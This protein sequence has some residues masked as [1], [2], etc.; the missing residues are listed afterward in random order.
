M[1]KNI[2]LRGPDDY[3]RDL[4]I[5]S[6]AIKASATYLHLQTGKDME[7][8]IAFVTNI[9]STGGELSLIPKQVKVVR[10]NAV[11]DR[12][13]ALIGI[14]TLLTKVITDK[15]ILSGNMV[16]YTSS[17]IERSMTSEYIEG[18][19]ANRSVIKKTGLDAFQISNTTLYALCNNREYVLKVLNNSV[20]G[21]HASPHNP[22]YLK[23][24][25][26]ALCSN[27]RI[28]VSYS[29][30]STERLI[31]GNR[32]YYNKDMVIANILAIINNTDFIQ[33]EHIIAE[34]KLHI[35]TV[36]ETLSV[37]LRSIKFYWRN[38]N[39]VMGI[40]E[41]IEKLLP[42]HRVA[43]VYTGDLFH[44]SKFN[45]GLIHGFISKAVTRPDSLFIEFDGIPEEVVDNADSDVV[46]LAG[47]LCADLLAGS[48][49]SKLK[50]N[51]YEGYV[52]YANTICNVNK[53]IDE[54]SDLL[55]TL[56][57]TENVPGSINEFPASIR[58]SVVG[59]DTDSTMFTVQEW[60]EWYFGKLIFSDEADKVA[61]FL[62][63]LNTQIIAHMLAM[64]SKQMG[65]SNTNLYK[66][67]M[68]N[69]FYFKIYMRAN[70]AKHYAT[71]QAAREGNV[72]KIPHIEIKGVALKDSKVP[73][74]I[75]ERLENEIKNIMTRITENRGVNIY[76]VMQRIVNLEHCIVN[77][78]KSG[79][80]T[81]LS[82]VNVTTVATKLL[83]YDLWTSVYERKYGVIETP[84]YRGVKISTT[85][86]KPRDMVKWLADMDPVTAEPMKIWLAKT[87]RTN[88]GMLLLPYELFAG[89]L[90]SEFSS[91]ID[92]RRIVTEL[93]AGF[94][95]LLEMTGFY[96]KNK[97]SAILLFDEIIYRPEY[98][99]PGDEE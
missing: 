46:A 96:I 65:V 84:P 3:N 53:V 48:T 94:Y 55:V 37:I 95:I 82:T 80:I 54:Y 72:Y 29:N 13:R 14:D 41:F 61:A 86:N 76:S 93:M 11:G 49:P 12:E 7:S 56:F 85:L 21:A 60:I 59:S 4:D 74:L 58:R 70:R 78:L 45:P 6:N 91:L 18:K 32:H 92:I 88:L 25:H 15:D 63:Y 97:N 30:A 44:L 24:A 20:S 71:I 90:P 38:A 77:S 10:K 5:V 36:A 68:K 73:R 79:E 17:D 69:E 67:K 75:M 27:C 2:F 47:I 51:N 62:C 83:H 9:T 1:S 19:M 28:G 26:S 22:L 66:L 99:L 57:V 43:F 34:Y 35:P 89:G 8:C 31:S 50:D 81:Y 98:G 33:L 42:I 52:V 39:W 16:V 23:T 87:K 40:S 64:A